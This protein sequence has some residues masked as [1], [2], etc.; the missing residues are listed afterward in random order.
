MEESLENLESLGFFDMWTEE[1]DAKEDENVDH[2]FESNIIP[3]RSSPESHSQRKIVKHLDATR[4]DISSFHVN[5]TKK[6]IYE[7]RNEAFAL[8]FAQKLPNQILNISHPGLFCPSVCNTQKSKDSLIG[9]NY[10]L[11]SEAQVDNTGSDPL[12][13]KSIETV[14]SLSPEKS[15]LS[16]TF[17]FSPCKSPSSIY[18]HSKIKSS[19]GKSISISRPR[20]N[21]VKKLFQGEAGFNQNFQNSSNE[22]NIIFTNGFIRCGSRESISISKYGMDKSYEVFDTKEMSELFNKRTINSGS[23]IIANT[24]PSESLS[25]EDEIFGKDVFNAQFLEEIEKTEKLYL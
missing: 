1:Q 12:S 20:R 8:K 5:G 4:R 25:T 24:F 10:K 22:S 3:L 13:I 2:I 16:K 9:V 21:S 11:S 6:D 7:D 19:S 17:S 23:S 18:G 14:K 15:N